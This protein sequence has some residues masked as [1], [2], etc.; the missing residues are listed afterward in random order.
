MQNLLLLRSATGLLAVV[1]GTVVAVHGTSPQ[2]VAA[3]RPLPTLSFD[4]T[5]RFAMK[6]TAD[7]ASTPDQTVT[8]RVYIDGRRIRAESQVGDRSIIYLFAP[9]FGYK[10]LPNSKTGLRYHVSASYK[11]GKSSS[12]D[13][14]SL[15]PLLQNPGELRAALHKQGGQRTGTSQ[16]NGTPVDVYTGT[17]LQGQPVKVKAWL[18]QSDALPARLELASRKLTVVASWRNYQHG[19]PLAN[20]LFAVPAGYHL[21]DAHDAANEQ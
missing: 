14:Q 18:R 4:M 1:A 7:D 13:P 12:F 19:R 6:E 15:L 10:L 9:P 17:K 20:A 21:R 5:A 16:L 2:A 3:P 8:A 11:I